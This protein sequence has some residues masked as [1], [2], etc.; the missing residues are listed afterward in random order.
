MVISNY[1][2]SGLNLLMA[3]S[4]DVPQYLAIGTGSGAEVAT[5]GSLITEAGANR[6]GF[7]SRDI[8]VANK[9]TWQFDINSV[10][11]S[12]ITLTEFGIGG[13]QAVGVNDL[14]NRE[15][16]IGI[17]FDGTNELQIE[18]LFEVF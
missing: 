17:E 1:G 15:A 4:A 6:T 11:M 18:I 2:R 5:L 16:F 13:S 7:T 8:S 10:N 14:W 9:T 3:G 12:G